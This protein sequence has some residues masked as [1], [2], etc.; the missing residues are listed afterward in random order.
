METPYELLLQVFKVMNTFTIL[1][2]KQ[3]KLYFRYYIIYTNH[4]V[5]L[6]VH[7]YQHST[8]NS[9]SLQQISSTNHQNT[10]PESILH[11]QFNLMA[12]KI[13][14]SGSNPSRST[15]HRS[16]GSQNPPSSHH[17]RRIRF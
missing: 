6:S 2:L 8:T 3:N 13:Y 16:N 14:L 11:L 15:I 5:F 1:I 17:R 7:H 4:S 12:D 10:Y 9:S